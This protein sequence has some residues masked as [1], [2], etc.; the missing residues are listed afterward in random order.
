MSVSSTLWSV[1]FPSFS[2]DEQTELKEKVLF[3][4]EEQI[5]QHIQEEKISS[6]DKEFFLLYQFICSRCYSNAAKLVLDISKKLNM[7]INFPDEGLNQ[8]KITDFMSNDEI[9]IENVNV[10]DY[11]EISR[12]ILLGKC[13][14]AKYIN[15][16]DNNLYINSSEYT[17]IPKGKFYMG[18]EKIS[19][20][21]CAIRADKWE[22]KFAEYD[23]VSSLWPIV[24][25]KLFD[26]LTCLSQRNMTRSFRHCVAAA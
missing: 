7:N 12:Q 8:I 9:T 22:G 2:Y 13:I 10:Q 1:Q 11:Q 6:T 18:D 17:D 21:T 23:V 5:I 26:K 3:N 24:N 4:I 15:I 19:L 16:F 20:S 25:S 14:N